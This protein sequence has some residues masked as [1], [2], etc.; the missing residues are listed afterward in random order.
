[1]KI[2]TDDLEAGETLSMEWRREEK[3]ELLEEVGY[4]VIVSG[5]DTIAPI[6]MRNVSKAVGFEGESP[7]FERKAVT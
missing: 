7:S 3:I 1:L 6:V 2:H 5:I 4:L